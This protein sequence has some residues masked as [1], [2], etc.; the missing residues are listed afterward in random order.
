MEEVDLDKLKVRH[1]YSLIVNT[2]QYS[3][4]SMKE[5][6][7]VAQSSQY[8]QGDFQRW[9]PEKINFPPPSSSAQ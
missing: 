5:V 8:Q 2:L 1:T 6:L 4:V 7:D 3:P 9:R